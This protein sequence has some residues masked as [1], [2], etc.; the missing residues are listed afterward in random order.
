VETLQCDGRFFR[1]GE[2]GDWLPCDALSIVTADGR[3]ATSQCEHS[4]GRLRLL[5][6]GAIEWVTLGAERRGGLATNV[7]AVQCEGQDLPGIPSAGPNA[8]RKNCSDPTY[9]P[10]ARSWEDLPPAIVVPSSDNC[11][12]YCFRTFVDSVTKKAPRVVRV[13][14]IQEDRSLAR[15]TLNRTSRAEWSYL[16]IDEGRPLRFVCFEKSDGKGGVPHF[17]DCVQ[18]E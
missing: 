9:D 2:T 17:D 1:P 14:I 13:A 10:D 18:M 15:A 16:A 5:T 8:P 11:V 7:L 6:N 12:G 4:S 3:D